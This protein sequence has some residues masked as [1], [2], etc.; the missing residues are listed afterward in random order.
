MRPAVIIPKD[1]SKIIFLLIGAL[2]FVG[3]GCW[4]AIDPPG[5]KRSFINVENVPVRIAGIISILFFGA[6]SFFLVKKLAD[7][8]PALIIDDAGITLNSNA[9]SFGFIPWD[10]I[11]GSKRMKV[12]NQSFLVVFVKHPEK[13]M[14]NNN[15]FL[16][17]ALKTNHS[18]YGSPISISAHGMKSSFE[19]VAR[20]IEE[21]FNR[22]NL[23]RR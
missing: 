10:E 14:E 9:Y 21:N 3:A 1:N 17:N 19:K 5:I 12:I 13:Y 16:K 4:M 23:L 7:K 22:Q 11:T 18:W 8:R 20:L 2:G 6:C 15:P